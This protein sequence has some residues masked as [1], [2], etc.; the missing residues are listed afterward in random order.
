MGIDRRRF[1]SQIRGRK[2]QAILNSILLHSVAPKLAGSALESLR[3]VEPMAGDWIKLDTHI[4]DKPEVVAIADELGEPETHVVGCLAWVW[5]WFD[6]HT[7]DGNAASVTKAFLNRRVGVTGFAEAMEKVGWL[8]ATN[9]GLIM[10]NFDA[11]NGKSAKKRAVTARRVANHKAKKGNAEVTQEALPREEK[12]R[13]N[14]PPKAPPRENDVSLPGLNQAAWS[15]YTAYRRQARMKKLT[16]TSADKL[17]RWLVEQGDERHQAA[18]VEQ[19]IRNNWQGL[20][21]LKE[22]GN[23]SGRKTGTTSASNRAEF[24]AEHDAAVFERSPGDLG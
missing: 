20:F 13:I 24:Q 16:N 11:H 21:P 8:E 19:T 22:N 23:G 17:M 12:R 14:S 2:G 10:P 18:I 6:R 15:D 5:A 7:E 3:D 4:F 9:N 1:K